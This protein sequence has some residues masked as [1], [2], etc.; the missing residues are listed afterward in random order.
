M[1]LSGHATPPAV[2][3]SQEESICIGATSSPSPLL[4]CCVLVARSTALVPELGRANIRPQT[5]Q[6]AMVAPELR[7]GVIGRPPRNGCRR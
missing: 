1:L 5:L 7:C 2:V 3:P 6:P 4:A